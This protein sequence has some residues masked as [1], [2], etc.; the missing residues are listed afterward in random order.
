MWASFT[1]GQKDINIY[2]IVYYINLVILLLPKSS[3]ESEVLATFFFID[4]AYKG[5]WP[6]IP[7]VLYCIVLIFYIYFVK[8][9]QYNGTVEK[10]HQ[11]IS[12]KANAR[13]SRLCLIRSSNRYTDSQGIA[14]SLASTRFYLFYKSYCTG[15]D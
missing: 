9:I 5:G 14:T 1:E 15:K 10:R 13:R 7:I 12:L 6:A 2:N 8:L 4:W 3:H 11:C